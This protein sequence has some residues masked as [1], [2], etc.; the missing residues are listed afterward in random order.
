[1]ENETVSFG[2][3]LINA[4]CIVFLWSCLN[5]QPAAPELNLTLLSIVSP[6]LAR[7][8]PL[9]LPGCEYRVCQVS[10]RRAAPSG[11]HKSLCSGAQRARADDAR[12]QPGQPLEN[13]AHSHGA[14]SSRY[15]SRKKVSRSSNWDACLPFQ[16]LD[17][18]LDELEL[19]LMLMKP[20]RCVNWLAGEGLIWIIQWSKLMSKVDSQ[21]YPLFDQMTNTHSLLTLPWSP[22][23]PSHL[24]ETPFIMSA[25]LSLRN[26]CAIPEFN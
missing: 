15:P 25:P 6:H 26:K 11:I 14:P 12:A 18:I 24:T 21:H 3:R 7:V 1:M 16:C 17:L 22:S 19:L 2:P 10:P 13:H 4:S 20:Q 5:P 8:S 23:F 9:L